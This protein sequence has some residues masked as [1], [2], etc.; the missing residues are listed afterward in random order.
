M[1]SADVND[2]EESE[3]EMEPVESENPS[4]TNPYRQVF[5]SFEIARSKFVQGRNSFLEVLEE[6]DA[7]KV[8]LSDIICNTAALYFRINQYF[9]L[10]MA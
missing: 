10:R 9:V 7:K 1:E 5:A 8:D 6:K 4:T 3:P 2:E